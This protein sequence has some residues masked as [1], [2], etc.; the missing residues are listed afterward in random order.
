MKP[1]YVTLCAEGT[2]DDMLLPIARWAFGQCL[3]VGVA[4]VRLTT[5][6][7]GSVADRVRLALDSGHC[8]AL[9]VHRDED[10]DGYEARIQEI[11]AAVA[12]LRDDGVEPPAH[13][14]VVPVRMSEAWLLFDEVAIRRAAGWANGT[15]RLP[16]PTGRHD[17]VANPK[18]ALQDALAAASGLTGRRLK[19]FRRDYRPSDVANFIDD[20]SPLRKLAAFRLFEAE[21]AAFA[22]RWKSDHSTEAEPADGP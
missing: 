15:A 8:D 6:K 2:T 20:F 19:N 9:L 22:A 21:V 3:G 18:Q 5:R 12:A 10:G 7:G 1:L 13:V 4:E 11:E 14:R 16:L 17:R